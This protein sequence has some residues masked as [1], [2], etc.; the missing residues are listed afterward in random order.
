PGL[1]QLFSDLHWVSSFVSIMAENAAAVQQRTLTSP[2]TGCQK[3]LTRGL[4]PIFTASIR[5]G[6]G[7]FQPER[8]FCGVRREIFRRSTNPLAT[9]VAVG[10][11]MPDDIS[12][13]D[14]GQG[15][16]RRS[17]LWKNTSFPRTAVPAWPGWR[18]PTRP[19]STSTRCWTSAST[20]F[21]AA[22]RSA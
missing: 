5:H 1:L 20:C 18:P 11:N 19:T 4:H 12:E 17:S 6:G 13:K 7:H 15:P 10:Y 14:G 16:L 3:P 21:R 8:A 22:A 9:L 2:G